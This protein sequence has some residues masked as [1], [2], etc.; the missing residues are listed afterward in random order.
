MTRP[1]DAAFLSPGFLVLRRIVY[2]IVRTFKQYRIE[3]HVSRQRPL[4]NSQSSL[5]TDIDNDCQ[6]DTIWNYLSGQPL[7]LGISELG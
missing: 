1:S 7:G 4:A 2:H 5:A 3:V 6:F